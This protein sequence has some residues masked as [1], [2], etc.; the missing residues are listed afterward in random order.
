MD[1]TW[2]GLTR[3]HG[4]AKHMASSR[5]HWLARLVQITHATCSVFSSSPSVM[6][7]QFQQFKTDVTLPSQAADVFFSSLN[8]NAVNAT[9]HDRLQH[10]KGNAFSQASSLH[11]LRICAYIASAFQTSNGQEHC[12]DPG[13]LITRHG[14]YFLSATSC[15][16]LHAWSGYTQHC[17]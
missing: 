1:S 13:R 2:V 5:G 12:M 14:V 11:K 4:S 17:R 10:C 16:L 15:Q 7:E 3:R 9:V 8:L 6:I